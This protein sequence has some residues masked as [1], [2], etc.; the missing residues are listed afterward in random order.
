MCVVRE[1]GCCWS[2]TCQEMGASGKV[3]GFISVGTEWLIVASHWERVL[4]MKQ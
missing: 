4:K 3:Q 1:D 2:S